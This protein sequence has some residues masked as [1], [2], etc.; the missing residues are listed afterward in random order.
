MTISSLVELAGLAAILIAPAL[1]AWLVL[2]R[3]R[4]SWTP[5]AEKTG[6][7]PRADW[8]DQSNSL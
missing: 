6:L 3:N 7:P 2:R 5:K 1:I 8:P 4:R